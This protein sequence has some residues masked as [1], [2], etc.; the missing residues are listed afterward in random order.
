MS[1]AVLAEVIIPIVVAIALAGWIVAIYRANRH[2]AHA[3]H[4]ESSRG[5][6]TGREVVGG[7]FQGPGGRQLMPLPNIEPGGSERGGSAEPDSQAGR[8]ES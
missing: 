2:P 7:S 1:K 8:P 5:P 4:T 3:H 6:R